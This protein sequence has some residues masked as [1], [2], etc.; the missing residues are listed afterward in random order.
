MQT[1]QFKNGD[2]VQ[3]LSGGAVMTVCKDNWATEV[4]V[5]WT[6]KDGKLY[7]KDFDHKLLKH[8]QPETDN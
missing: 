5:V 3:L 7:E 8:Y 2:L 6:D 4:S 1:T